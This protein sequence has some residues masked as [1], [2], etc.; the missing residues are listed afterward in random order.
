MDTVV[1]PRGIDAETGEFLDKLPFQAEIIS[2]FEYEDHKVIATRL[3][4]DIDVSGDAR[5]FYV[6]KFY[7]W[8]K[9]TNTVEFIPFESVANESPTMGSFLE[10]PDS[11]MGG[12]LT[13]NNQEKILY[14]SGDYTETD[15]TNTSNELIA[16]YRIDE[17]AKEN[18]LSFIHAYDGKVIKVSGVAT[19]VMADLTTPAPVASEEY[20]RLLPFQLD[21]KN[22]ATFGNYQTLKSDE[23]IANR[24]FNQVTIQNNNDLEQKERHCYFQPNVSG[25]INEGDT[26]SAIIWD[27]GRG[28]SISKGQY[29]YSTRNQQLATPA[30]P[31]YTAISIVIDIWRMEVTD[32]DYVGNTVTLGDFYQL[33][34]NGIFEKTN[35]ARV[36]SSLACSNV[37]YALYGSTDLT[38]GYEFRSV[39]TYGYF[40]AAYTMDVTTSS[41]IVPEISY[42]NELLFLNDRFEDTYDEETVKLPPPKVRAFSRYVGS[43]IAVDDKALYFSD[44]SLGG[45]IETFTPFDTFPVGSSEFGPITGIFGNETFLAVFRQEESYYISGNIFTANYRIQSYKSTR[46]GCSD[47][48]SIIDYRGAGVF[49]SE[50][51]IFVC[52]QGGA[53]EELSDIIEPLFSEDVLGLSL[54]MSNVVGIVDFIGERLLFS[55]GEYMVEFNYYHKEWLLH[56]GIPMSGGAIISNRELYTSDGLNV[57]KEAGTYTKSTAYRV[58][59]FETLQAPSLLKKFHRVLIFT[60]SMPTSFSLGIN[61]YKNW[62]LSERAT[63]EEKDGEANQVD[64]T[65]RLNPASVKSMAMEIYSPSGQPFISEGYEYEYGGFSRDFQDDD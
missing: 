31:P 19:N 16:G 33:N 14:I 17:N 44:F 60:P 13:A 65:Q 62:D 42:T 1:I 48:R 2:I 39:S 47:P 15:L 53:M 30:V 27:Q 57:F 26:I 12:R 5:Y 46:I 8:F 45:N 34:S 63:E 36:E 25:N 9:D 29:V 18:N 10:F 52:S 49:A 4:H 22:R 23:V 7:K 38:F 20:I 50:K 40:N 21:Y 28:K 35:G 3:R 55:F 61:T 58:S 59:N 6:N 32:V 11:A 56:D 37:L 41:G 64:V 54:D 43:F 51:G 24:D